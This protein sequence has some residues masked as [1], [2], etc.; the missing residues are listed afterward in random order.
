[1]NM[2]NFLL[3]ILLASPFLLHAQ[4]QTIKVGTTTRNMIVYVPSG[5]AAD[6]P[7][8]ISLH[9]MNQDAPYQQNQTK[10][11]TIADTAKFALVY[12]NGNNKSWD[13]NGNGDIDFLLAI[14]DTMYNRHKIDKNRVYV[15]GFSMGGMMSYHTANKIGNKI[16]AIGPVSG[17]LFS[18]VAASS[19][20]MPIIHVHGDADDV[21]Q[22]SGVSGMLGKW[23]TLNKCPTTATTIKPYPASKPASTAKWEYWG[24]C[25]KSEVVLITLGGKGHW[26]SNDNAGVHSSHEIWN[27][28]KKW[29]LTGGSTPTSSTISSST[30]PSSSSVAVSQAAYSSASIPGIIQA[31]NYDIGGAG[32]AYQDNEPANNGNMYRTDGVDI[33]GDATTGYKVGWTIKGEWLEYTLNVAVAGA[34]AW[35]ASV[36]AGGD[37]S[38]FRL[39]LDS[40]LDLTGLV[41]VPNTTS[42]D[43]YSTLRGSTP[44]LP[45]GKHILRLLIEGS[46]VNVDWMKFSEAPTPLLLQ[47]KI[48]LKKSKVPQYDLLGRGKRL[49]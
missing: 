3:G 7:L 36:A 48:S 32:V 2:K 13:I 17:Y 5:L 35:E 8:L 16:A 28:L 30:I 34:Y 29:S 23:R 9:G 1:M 45:A 12:P 19:R 20:P 42:W 44:T 37:G 46:Y 6:R 24:P 39:L 14:I 40:T 26:H 18:G 49:R 10:W 43:T 33:T 38:S 15:S 22:Y 47:P 41:E 21:V 27:F 31:E 4:S 25:D 11:E